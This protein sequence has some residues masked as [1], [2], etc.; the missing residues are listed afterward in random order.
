[1]P[2]DYSNHFAPLS[3]SL[4]DEIAE[5]SQAIFSP[6]PIDY[7]WRLT[8]MPNAGVFCARSDGRLVGFKAGYAMAERKYYSWLGAVHPDHRR[9]GIATRLTAMQHEW[10]KARGYSIVEA[11]CRDDNAAMARVNLAAG[12]AVVGTKLEPHGLQVLWSKAL[13]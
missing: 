1:M 2:I 13:S 4:I 3:P 10:M 7:S 6:P 8:N 9:H 5:L 11:S 12:F